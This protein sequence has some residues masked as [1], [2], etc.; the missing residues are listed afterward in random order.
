MATDKKDKSLV[1]M[2]AQM[3]KKKKMSYEDIA[4]RGVIPASLVEQIE[5]GMISPSIGALKK[6]TKALE[7]PMADFFQQLGFSEKELAKIEASQEVMHIPKGQRKT[8]GVKG[9]RAV[10]QYLTP[11]KTER[12]LELLWQEVEAKASGGDWLTHEGEECCLVISGSFRIYVGEEIYDLN[13]GDTLWF[14]THQR[15]KW[16]NLSDDPAIVI[17]AITPPY[18]GKI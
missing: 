10:I 6:I 4:E 8:L 18:H 9:S 15:H 3:R 5:K 14:R 1:E 17:W 2:L 12:N 7:I 11:T 13:E 16:E